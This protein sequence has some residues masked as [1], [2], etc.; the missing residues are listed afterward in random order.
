MTSTLR[1]W[2]GLVT[3]LERVEDLASRVRRKILLHRDM[4]TTSA[5]GHEGTHIEVIT[6]NKHGSITARALT[7]D[8]N[9][10]ELAVLGRLARFDA[11]EVATDGVKN[12]VR[13]AEHTRRRRADLNEVF[14]N[15]FPVFPQVQYAQRCVRGGRDAHGDGIGTYRLNM[16]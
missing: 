8:F 7:L 12:V 10:G 9:D 5:Q 1:P 13:A 15:R 6:D 14:A 11:A 2:L 4:R 16:V 3:L